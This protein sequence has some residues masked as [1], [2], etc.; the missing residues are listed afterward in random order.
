MPFALLK[1][2]IV[3]RQQSFKKNWNYENSLNHWSIDIKIRNQLDIDIELPS[4]YGINAI[5]STFMTG[6][7]YEYV[8][9]EIAIEENIQGDLLT[10]QIS[11]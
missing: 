3:E 9:R 2:F 11:S 6:L 4:D 8:C 10:Y 7:N 1:Y 5:S